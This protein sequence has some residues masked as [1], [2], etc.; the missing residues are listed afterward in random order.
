MPTSPSFQFAFFVSAGLA[1]VGAI[2]CWILVRQAPRTLTGPIF[3]RRSRWVL[4]HPGATGQ[5]LTRDPP[6]AEAGSPD[7]RE[8]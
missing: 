5:G 2:S 6:P 1:V 4:A 3:G 7:H 8:R